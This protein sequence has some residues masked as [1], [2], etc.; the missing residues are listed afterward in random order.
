MDALASCPSPTLH[1]PPEPSLGASHSQGW[2]DYLDPFTWV[3]GRGNPSADWGGLLQNYYNSKM[4]FPAGIPVRG[5]GGCTP[6]LTFLQIQ[7]FSNKRIFSSL[8]VY[9]LFLFILRSFTYTCLKAWIF[10][11]CLHLIMTNT[12]VKLPY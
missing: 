8:L 4:T 2:E 10:T 1:L 3:E 7:E 12:Y 9:C 11:Y 5:V 6:L